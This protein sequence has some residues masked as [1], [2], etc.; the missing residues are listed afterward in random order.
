MHRNET[1]DIAKGVGIL[2]VVLGH[3][4]LVGHDYGLPLLMIFSFHMPLFFLLGGVFLSTSSDLPH[5]IRSK[6]DTLLKPYI[7]VLT[8][9]GTFHVI[10]GT[11]TPVKYFGGM[12]YG[13]GSTIVWTAMW[14]LPS[15]FV[16]LVFA[17]LIISVMDRSRYGNLGLFIATIAL[18]IIGACS[19][20]LFVDINSKAYPMLMPL[21]DP[22][23]HILGLPFSLDLLPISSAF[24][25]SGYLLRGKIKKPAFNSAHLLVAMIIFLT[26][27]V[28]FRYFTDLNMRVY[29]HWLITPVCAMSG[30]YIVMSL[31]VLINDHLRG[32]SR[33]L[34]YLGRISLFILIFHGYVELNLVDKLT[35]RWPIGD[36]LRAILGLVAAV[37]I[38]V[39]IYEITRRITPLAWLL[40]P[41]PKRTELS[42]P[43]AGQVTR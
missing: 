9:L 7:V 34:S 36:Y 31:S 19:V 1:I 38:P 29:D 43:A 21:F 28:K 14:F 41:I 22:N 4:W 20:G 10:T 35:E 8:L 30:I 15:L 11:V 27:N 6:A 26:L 25:L 40:L 16:T 42:N 37:V 12:L 33:V 5:F 18:F 24:L 13:V 39:I 32:L 3:N 23:K 2:L 17:R